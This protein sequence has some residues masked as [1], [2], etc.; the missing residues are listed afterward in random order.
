MITMS[1]TAAATALTWAAA[2]IIAPAAPA[3][4]G[5]GGHGELHQQWLLAVTA[6]V[7][8]ACV[9]TAIVVHRRLSRRVE[10]ENIDRA[11]DDEYRALEPRASAPDPGDPPR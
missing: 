4:Q 2:T 9:V 7:F 11:L 6:G 10:L 1:T 8:V 3:P 5:L